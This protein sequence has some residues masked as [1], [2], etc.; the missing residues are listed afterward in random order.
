MYQ[1]F[2]NSDKGIIH[3]VSTQNVPKKHDFLPPNARTGMCISGV[4]KY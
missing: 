3:L 2:L 4:K 1:I